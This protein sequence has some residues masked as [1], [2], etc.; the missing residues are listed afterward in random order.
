MSVLVCQLNRSTQHFI[1]EV[2]RSALQPWFRDFVVVSLRPRRRSCGIAGRKGS[3]RKRSGERSVSRHRPFITKSPHT[4]G[5]VR[6]RGVARG[7]HS[8]L[9]EREEDIQ[10][11]SGP[12]NRPDRWPDCWAARPRR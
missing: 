10:A 9:A 3:L 5:F 4:E 12:I 2:E 8:T 6:L 7:W 11:H 1:L